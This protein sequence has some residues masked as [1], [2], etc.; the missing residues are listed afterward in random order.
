MLGLFPFRA[1]ITGYRVQGICPLSTAAGIKL[2]IARQANIYSLLS[3]K[4][5]YH[6]SDFDSHGI[7]KIVQYQIPKQADKT[8]VK[9]PHNYLTVAQPGLCKCGTSL[10]SITARYIY[11]SDRLSS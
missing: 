11:I 6:Y 9:L 1:Q 5:L 10:F 8:S 2:L 7:A 4:I 3:M